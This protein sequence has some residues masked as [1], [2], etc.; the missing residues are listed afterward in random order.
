MIEFKNLTKK[1]IQTNEFKKLY[2]KIFIKNFELSIV[3]AEPSLM[4]SLNKKYRN[5]NKPADVLSFQLEKRRGEIFLNVEK[6]NL[7]YLFLHGALHLKGM[8]HQNIREAEKMEA[9]E[10]KLLKS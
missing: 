5:K 2:K 7:S 1:K 6:K 3:F 9:L 8:A 4:L 10:K